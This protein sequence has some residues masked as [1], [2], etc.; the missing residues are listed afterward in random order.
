[1]YLY[2]ISQHDRKEKIMEKILIPSE[3]KLCGCL[4]YKDG[5]IVWEAEGYC[6][7]DHYEIDNE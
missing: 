6:C 5:G 3:C 1:M 7:S 2:A 4:Y